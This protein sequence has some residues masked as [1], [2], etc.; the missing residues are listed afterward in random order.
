MFCLEVTT[1]QNPHSLSTQEADWHSWQP[2]C[3]SV[4][5]I[6][7]TSGWTCQW[8]E[9]G[10]LSPMTKERWQIL[11]CC[12]WWRDLQADL[13]HHFMWAASPW[14]KVLCMQVIQTKSS[15]TTCETQVGETSS[16]CSRNKKSHQV[17]RDLNSKSVWWNWRQNTEI[18][19]R[20]WLNWQQDLNP[21]GKRKECMLMKT[22]TK[23]WKTSWTREQK[24]YETTIPTQLIPPTFLGTT[25]GGDESEGYESGAVAPDLP[26]ILHFAW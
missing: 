12:S 23:I 9:R 6:L 16:Q 10:S 8:V 14:A 3:K 17:Q 22:C 4:L 21:S 20:K 18:A 5:D 2:P 19:N 7:S 15:Y 13:T 11:P 24:R 25:T 1:T 26:R